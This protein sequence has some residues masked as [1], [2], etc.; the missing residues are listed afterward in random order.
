MTNPALPPTDEPAT[1]APARDDEVPRFGFP[2]PL[3]PVRMLAGVLS[4]WPWI[5]L[6]MI[7]FAVLGAFAGKLITKQ[8]FSIS[9]ALI[10]QRV[11]Q[12]VQTS[13]IGQSFR[14]ADLNDAT[15]LATLL[16]SEPR[17]LAFTKADNGLSTD[18]ASSLVE[19]SQLENT[20]IFYITYHSPVS[21]DDAMH[22]AGI[23]AREICEYTQ[24][25]QQSE[26][27]SVLTILA[28]EVVALEKR[29]DDTNRELLEFAKTNDF[30]G[31]ES[32]VAAIL[33]K[34]SQ[35]ELK[36]D[37]ARTAEK[38]LT[39]QLAELDGKIRHHSPLMLSLRAAREELANLRSTYTDDNP[40]VQT[41]LESIAYL[42]NQLDALGDGKA[43]D[44]ESFTGTP[45][46]NQLYLDIIAARSRL[47]EAKT[48]INALESQ[49]VTTA[50]RLA[51]FPAIISQY[52]AL[53]SKRE[54]YLS[55]L[56]LM[57]KRLKE[58]E[59]FASSS[60]GSWQIF[61]KPDARTVIP[62]SLTKKPLLLGV[63]G[64]IAGAG[65][66]IF[67]TLLLTHR[68]T[69]RSV[70]ECCA[71]T[72]APLAALLPARHGEKSGFTD[73]WIS[74]LAPVLS[75]SQNP[76]MLWSAAITPQ[77]ERFFWNELSTA[78]IEDTGKPL[79]V[80]DLTPDTL[81]QDS[82]PNDSIVWKPNATPE[83]GSFIRAHE[84]PDSSRRKPL[85]NIRVWHALVAGEKS[86]LT[87]YT[88]S[89]HLASVYLPP[90]TGTIAL[91]E[92]ASGIIRKLADQLSIFLT[93][94]FS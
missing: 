77:D 5:L 33:G 72:S 43:A 94:R 26:A 68:S 51:R 57:G 25:L 52:D 39:E 28:K 22:V 7:V 48:R 82:P 49:R 46:G 88:T 17:D 40:L 81:W 53:R 92:P 42:E 37:D 16:A 10:K 18:Q 86:S 63:A 20:D 78:A 38:A 54:S 64:A 12:T 56:S 60:P 69:R 19:A 47:T 1:P 23:W 24:R 41:K 66:A 83:P 8:T 74:T 90:C 15:L 13:E 27:R 71:T 61:Q 79:T 4:R 58:A 31:G 9:V 85:E 32:Q 6:G 70:L 44:L 75:S 73:L 89:Q 50:E 35:I 21:A 34:L 87:R 93:R 76:P 80:I 67:V 55:E 84:L 14:P 59:I 45:L 11:P 65:L 29:I 30:I 62:S 91:S 3:D 36:L 2:V